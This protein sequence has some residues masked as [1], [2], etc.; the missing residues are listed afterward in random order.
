MSITN[1]SATELK[2]NVSEIIDNVRLHR[3][4]A[5]VKKYGRP[6]VK[7][8]PFEE[9]KNRIGE[10]TLIAKTYGSLPDFPDVTKQRKSR[11]RSVGL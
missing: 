8:I 4:I 1:I 3:T 11:K 7:I 2:N 6:M 10:E 9:E 5:I